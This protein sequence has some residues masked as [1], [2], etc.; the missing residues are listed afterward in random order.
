[1]QKE[2]NHAHFSAG[3]SQSMKGII[4]RQDRNLEMKGEADNRWK[5]K[6]QDE[7]KREPMS[8]QNVWGE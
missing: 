4:G 1:M 6:K 7:G 5:S 8:A 3:K 2:K